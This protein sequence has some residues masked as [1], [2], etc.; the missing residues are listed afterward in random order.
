MSLLR[1]YNNISNLVPLAGPDLDANDK[2]LSSSVVFGGTM[3]AKPGQEGFYVDD[4][5]IRY[6]RYVQNRS[7]AARAMGDVLRRIADVAFSGPTAATVS[8][9]TKAGAFTANAHPGKILVYETNASAGAAPEGESAIIVSNTAD[10]LQ[11][12]ANYPFSAVPGI[13]GGDNYRII[14]PQ[15]HGD[16]AGA[17]VVA[18]DVLGVVVGKNGID[19]GNFGWIQ[20]HGICPLVAVS[21]AGITQGV[22]IVTAASGKVQ[23][24]GANAANTVI[25]YSLATIAATNAGKYPMFIGL[26]G[27]TAPTV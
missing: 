16:V 24:I 14:S 18:R 11:L 19:D 8:K 17:A 13:A 5:G 7:G 4:F 10:V 21:A 3:R 15:W 12:D 20:F 22:A 9:I 25:G 2:P 1:S 27:H 6:F 26:D 23:T